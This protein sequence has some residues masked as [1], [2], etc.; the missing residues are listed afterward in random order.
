MLL[1]LQVNMSDFTDSKAKEETWNVNE[2][3]FRFHHLLRP[4]D[5]LLVLQ[6]MELQ[7]TFSI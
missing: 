4:L 2:N 3:P 5:Q 7:L 1:L 6:R